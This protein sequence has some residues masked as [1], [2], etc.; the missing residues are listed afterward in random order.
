MC[1]VGVLDWMWICISILVMVHGGRR[2]R[3]SVT[4]MMSQRFL[5]SV[6]YRNDIAGQDTAFTKLDQAAPTPAK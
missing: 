1:H 6:Q 2:I 3:M 4:I 5:L